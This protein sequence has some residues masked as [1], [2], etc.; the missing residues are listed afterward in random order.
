MGRPITAGLLLMAGVPW[1]TLLAARRLVGR[2]PAPLDALVAEV[3]AAA[4]IDPARRGAAEEAAVV[5]VRLAIRRGQEAGHAVAGRPA[6][7]DGHLGGPAHGDAP[8]A[9]VAALDRR[10]ADVPAVQGVDAVELI[11]LDG[12]AMVTRSTWNS[13]MPVGSEA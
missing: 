13:V 4:L 12:Q 11:A 6:G 3:D 10:E 8:A 9:V 1:I 5:D 7:V 2:F